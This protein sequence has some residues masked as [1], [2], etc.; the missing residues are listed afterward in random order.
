MK[1]YI[2]KIIVVEGKEDVSYL[3]SFIEAEYITTNGYDIPKEEVEYINEASKHKEVLVLVDPDKAGRQI[4]DKLKTKL[5]KATYIS[6]DISKCIRGEKDGVAEASKEEILRVLN[7]HFSS[8]NTQ[9]S[10]NSLVNL[11]KLDLTSKELRSYLSRKYH[12]GKCNLKKLL[13]RLETLEITVE[14][15]EQSIKEFYGN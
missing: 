8:K 7:P 15:L 13:V 9:K 3:S 10:R 12:L 5:V 6:I 2:N 4:E 11:S 1:Y 14:E